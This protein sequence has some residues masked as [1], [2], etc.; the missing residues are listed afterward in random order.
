[1]TNCLGQQKEL[2]RKGQL[3]LTKKKKTEQ[4]I[5]ASLLH[6]STILACYQSVLTSCSFHEEHNLKPPSRNSV[7][8][9]STCS[10]HATQG[11]A[12]PEAT[13][14]FLFWSGFLY[15]LQSLHVEH[16]EI[17]STLPRSIRSC[18]IRCL[19]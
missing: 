14:P 6:S 16:R 7:C 3:F 18:L 8:V 4:L 10:P 12:V 2:Q 13:I 1:M 19:S 17:C 15:Q 9:H 5:Q 11:S